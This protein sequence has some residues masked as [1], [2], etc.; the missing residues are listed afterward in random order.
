MNKRK[1]S[2]KKRQ[3]VL[4]YYESHTAKETS[5]KFKI[6]S[7]VIYKWKNE[8]ESNPEKMSISAKKLISEKY[9]DMS[10]T[11]LAY[12]FNAK[13]IA[14]QEIERMDK[15]GKHKRNRPKTI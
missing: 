14:L 2:D 12:I 13:R 4:K 5:D 6:T 1:Y 15:D 9:V 3:M 8:E 11:E 10:K 7:S